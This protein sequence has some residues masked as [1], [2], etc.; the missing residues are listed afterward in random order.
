[1]SL[2]IG[3]NVKHQ[4]F[5][6]GV[7]TKLLD[8]GLV[9]VVFVNEEFEKI[10]SPKF[11]EGYISVGDS[12]LTLQPSN[13]PADFLE[14]LFEV[15]D[16]VQIRIHYPKHAESFVFNL[17]SREGLELPANIRALDC[18]SHG[19]TTIPRT[20]AGEM[21]FPTPKNSVYVPTPNK[22]AKGITKISSLAVILSVLKAGFSITKYT[23]EKK[24]KA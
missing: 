17:F 7:I 18:G 8:K 1:M 5:G 21:W 9:K 13:L 20:L 10:V 2:R 12:I 23:K 19:G 16:R 4:Q 22:T 11:L 14:Y 24:E 3:Q 15:K 6:E